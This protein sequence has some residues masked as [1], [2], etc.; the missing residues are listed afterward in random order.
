MI[1]FSFSR[2]NESDQQLAF[3]PLAAPTA[4]SNS[5][6]NLQIQTIHVQLLL[7]APPSVNH[8]ALA[9]AGIPTE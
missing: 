8:N 9:C 6:P 3:S 4:K 7:M 1:S 5:Q 2:D